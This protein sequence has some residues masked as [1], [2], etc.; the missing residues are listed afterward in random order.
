MENLQ[1]AELSLEELNNVLERVQRAIGELRGTDGLEV[2]P[3][4]NV[5][6]NGRRVRGAG[7][8]RHANDYVTRRELERLGL[9]RRT[10]L[11]QLVKQQVDQAFFTIVSPQTNL[12]W[13]IENLTGA[14]GTSHTLSFTPVGRVL[15][16]L[17][18]AVLD[19]DSAP[20]SQTEFEVSGTT[21][22]TGRSVLATDDFVVAYQAAFTPVEIDALTGTTGTLH[23][24][25]RPPI[26]ESLVIPLLRGAK[27]VPGSAPLSPTEFQLT[28]TQ[29]ITTGRSVLATDD[30]VVLYPY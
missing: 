29:Q 13:K 24:L 30:F 27:L 10:N 1:L 18:G 15:V 12:A 9:Y 14:T 8:S 23:S 4:N 26:D 11:N 19:E 5:R 25:T 20:L 7:E 22:T 6:L 28:G 16:F 17:R 2:Q 3:S 21:L